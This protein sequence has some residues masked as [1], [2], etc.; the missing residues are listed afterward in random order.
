MGS[1]ENSP[2]LGSEL[3]D[4]HRRRNTNAPPD[5]P[6]LGIMSEDASRV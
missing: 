1:A 5:P 6:T 3:R 2:Q 4:C